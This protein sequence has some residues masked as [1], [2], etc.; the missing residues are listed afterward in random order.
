[1]ISEDGEQLG[2]KSVREAISIAQSREL[3]LI[4]IAPGANPPVCKIVD[5]S[6]FKYEMDKKRREA[7]K[8]QKAGHLKEIR[9]RPKIGAHDFDIK[10]KHIEEFIAA[11]DKVRVT[12]IFRGREMEHRELGAQ[13]LA[14]LK[15]RLAVTAELEQDAMLEGNRLSLMFVPRKK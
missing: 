1:M 6:K 13:L 11:R 14:T 15:E 2:I 7:K 5:F 9:I 10:I 4:E 8:K 3:D 12:V